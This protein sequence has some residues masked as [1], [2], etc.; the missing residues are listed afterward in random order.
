MGS[1][2]LTGSFIIGGIVLLTLLFV[3]SN[4][5]D[6]QR[7]QIINE[8]T[9]SSMV[10]MSNVVDYDFNKIG[11]R[12]TTNPKISSIN[13][14][15]IS[16]LSDLNNN[17]TVDSVKYFIRTLSGKQYLV[18]R[19]FENSASEYQ[20]AISNFLIQGYDSLNS[21]TFT[22]ANIKSVDVKIVIDNNAFR[23]DTTSNFGSYY[24]RRY[25]IHN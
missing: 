21:A 8:F 20:M 9:E 22:V 6:F 12:V 3:Q 5:K 16:F 24:Q 2:N 23:S 14:S 18:R 11:Y 7:S 4:I 19:T 17:G 10:S 25:F 1:I 13:G 15:S